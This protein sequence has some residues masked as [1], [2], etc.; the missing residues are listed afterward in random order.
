MVCGGPW[1]CFVTFAE[2]SGLP[3]TLRLLGRLS[4]CRAP[5]TH[6]SSCCPSCELTVCATALECHA[7]VP[8]LA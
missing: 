1:L 4:R 6:K 3:T 5:R 7:C 2:L 8:M